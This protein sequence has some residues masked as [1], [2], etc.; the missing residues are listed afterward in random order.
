MPSY[1][2][3]MQNLEKAQANWRRPRP[4]R[5]SEE[6][7]MIRRFVFLWLTCRDPADHPVALG[8]ENLASAIRGCRSW[9]ANFRQTRAKCGGCRK[10]EVISNSRISVADG[11]TR[12]R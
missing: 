5:S 3:S 7:D 8:P 6:G 11:N 2:S 9:F 1:E 10:G 4:W 12:S